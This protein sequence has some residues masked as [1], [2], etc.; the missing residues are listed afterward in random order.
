M[1]PK[2][3][4]LMSLRALRQ[5]R[6]TR[7]FYVAGALLWAAAAAWTGWTHPGSRQMWI[8]LFLVAVFTG[9]LG[10]ASLWLYRLQSVSE[11]KPTRHAASRGSITPGHANA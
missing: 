9:L 6:R 2:T 1:A 3:E 7:S 11:R 4:H 10:T 5:L 8:S